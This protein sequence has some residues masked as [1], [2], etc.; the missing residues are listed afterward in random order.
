MVEYQAASSKDSAGF[1]DAPLPRRRTVKLN[2]SRSVA[3]SSSKCPFQPPPWKQIDSI[4]F[5]YVFDARAVPEPRPEGTERRLVDARHRRRPLGGMVHRPRGPHGAD[6]VAVSRGCRK[7]DECSPPCCARWS[8]CPRERG[9]A[10]Q[11]GH[12]AR[13]K[14]TTERSLDANA[15]LA[16]TRATTVFQASRPRHW[17]T[18]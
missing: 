11:C 2:K 4:D 5:S 13:C 3:K 12:R 14:R 18:R 1:A 9:Y 16:R 15:R 10:R 8:P 7:A 6:I 17:S